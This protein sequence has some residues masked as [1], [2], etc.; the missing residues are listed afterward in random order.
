VSHDFR[1]PLAAISASAGSVLELD[2]RLDRATRTELLQSIQEQCARLD[3]YTRNLLNLVRIDGGLDALRMPVID[4]VEVLGGALARV[5]RL[6]GVHMI[7]RDFAVSSALVRA[8]ESL[9]EQVFSNVLENAVT[10]TPPGT[11]VQVSAT[12][13]GDFLIVAVED[14]GNGIP[15][16][17]RDRVFERFHQVGVDGRTST[18]NSGS[19]L[20]LSIARGFTELF[21]GAISARAACGAF[22]G[23][24]IEVTLP[25]NR[26]PH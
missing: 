2:E 5:R 23:A 17:E 25:L 9:L 8:D 15:P 26:D 20:G 16:V 21:G 7:Q 10:H 1:T 14:D 19:G 24:R 12:I 3:R 11:S 6:P 4:A 13:D 18:G 22:R